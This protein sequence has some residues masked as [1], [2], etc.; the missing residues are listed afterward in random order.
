MPTNIHRH[1][2]AASHCYQIYQPRPKASSRVLLLPHAG[3]S[4]SFFRPWCNAFSP[5]VEIVA[6]Q[7]PGREN[8]LQDPLVDN[9]AELVQQLAQQL[10]PVLDKPFLLFGHSMGGA[11]AYELYLAL[12]RQQLPLPR[13]LVLSACEGP[14]SQLASNWHQQPDAELLTELSRLNGTHVCFAS[15]PELAD[16][17]LPLVRNDYR[18]IETYQPDLRQTPIDCD[19]TVM[20]GK[21]DQELSLRDALAWQTVTSRTFA[22]HQFTGDHFYLRQQFPAIITE[23][24][25]LL[26]MQPTRAEH[27]CAP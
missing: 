3:G 6:I 18:L 11:V 17:V 22:V 19:L 21:S 23:L 4:A 24:S 9:M 8:R 25:R 5:E 1:P 15:F 16:L 2:T 27:I 12:A 10:R 13:H 14:G 7:Y 26:G 20:L